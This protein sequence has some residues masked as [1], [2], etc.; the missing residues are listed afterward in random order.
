MATYRTPPPCP[1]NGV[2]LSDETR[3]QLGAT[4]CCNCGRPFT[5]HVWVVA[6]RLVAAIAGFENSIMSCDWKPYDDTDTREE[7]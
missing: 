6:D 2:A 5:S 1:R 4:S 7:S 3:R